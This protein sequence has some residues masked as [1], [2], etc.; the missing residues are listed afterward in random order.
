MTSVSAARVPLHVGD[1]EGFISYEE[2]V[3]Y[4]MQK[5]WKGFELIL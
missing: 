2:T 4:E 1:E 5:L 3:V